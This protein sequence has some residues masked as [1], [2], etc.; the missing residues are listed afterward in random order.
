MSAGRGLC[1]GLETWKQEIKKRIG[2]YVYINN[3]ISLPAFDVLNTNK[4][5]M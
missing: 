2:G 5:I 3:R 4:E 1:K